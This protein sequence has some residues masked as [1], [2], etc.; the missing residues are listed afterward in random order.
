MLSMTLFPAH[1]LLAWALVG[2]RE[3]RFEIGALP[4]EPL[5]SVWIVLV[6]FAHNLLLGGSLGEELG[7]RGFLL[8][9]LL[10]RMSPLGASMVLGVVWGLWHL[11]IDLYA[12][13]GITGL[14]AIL[15]RIVFAVP[16]AVLFTW[17]YLRANGSLLVAILLHTSIN[18]M[19]D[20]AFSGYEATAMMFGL[21]I[22]ASA[23]VL[24]TRS[25]LLRSGSVH[26]RA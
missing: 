10:R 7:W 2:V 21:L 17:C 26:E 25:R 4:G 8:P 14:G 6:V 23:L 12:G 5:R 15:A 22:G 19:G 11:P 18:V 9:A 1:F 3:G 24:A 13:F 20:L 16:V